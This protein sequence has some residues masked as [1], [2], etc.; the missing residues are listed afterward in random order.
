MSRPLRHVSSIPEI[1]VSVATFNE[2]ARSYHGRGQSIVRQTKY[3]VFDMD[4]AW[5][6]PSKF[7]GFSNMTFARYESAL[8]RELS[9][10]RFHGN[11]ARTAVESVAGLRFAADPSLADGLVAWG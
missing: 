6:G 9:G 2:S 7:V 11:A 8:R 1:R 3:W 10:D 4:A 5:F